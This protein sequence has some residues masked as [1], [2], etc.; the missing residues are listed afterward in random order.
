MSGSWS[1]VVV[2]E[3]NFLEPEKCALTSKTA[4][5]CKI[6]YTAL[7]FENGTPHLVTSDEKLEPLMEVGG[8]PVYCSLP[9][10]AT[11]CTFPTQTMIYVS[12]RVFVSETPEIIT[13]WG[14]YP[15]FGEGGVNKIPPRQDR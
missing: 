4:S 8:F 7:C 15:V 1:C 12:E 9:C 6:S 14:G 11:L 13:L 5:V 3:Q 10:V 2:D